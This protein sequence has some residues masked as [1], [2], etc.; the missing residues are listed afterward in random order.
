MEVPGGSFH[1]FLLNRFF[2]RPES[3]RRY[4][5]SHSRPPLLTGRHPLFICMGLVWTGLAS[6]CGEGGR[7]GS[8]PGGDAP[9]PA[10]EP[11][12]L[13][14]VR[15]AV[16][17]PEHPGPSFPEDT[18]T[19]P[20]DTIL[21]AT[22][23]VGTP[24]DTVASASL[25][26]LPVYSTRMAE[27]GIREGEGGGEGSVRFPHPEHIRGIYLNA[28]TSGS[29]AGRG[30]LLE[31]AKRTELNAFVMDIKDASGYV[32]HDSQ[33]PLAREVGATG[34]RRIRDLP[35]LLEELEEAGVYPI[36]RIVVAKDP[37]L[38]KGRP[39]LAI[40]DSAGGPWEDQ[41]GVMWLNFYHPEVWQYHLDLAREVAEA[42]FPEIQWDYVRF[43]DAPEAYLSRAR[44]PHQEGRSRTQA[45]REFL[46]RSRDMLNGMGVRLTADVF[47]VTT[48]YRRDVGIGQL[49]ESFID[50]VD[51]ALPMV[52]P[53]HYWTGSFGYQEPNAYPY[54]IVRRAL[55]DGLKRSAEV[56][57]AGSIRPWLQD[58]SLG[59]P[60][61]GAPEVRAQIQ[62]AYDVGIQEW[63]LWNPGS[64]YTEAALIPAT[65]LP[66]W[67]EPV[68]RVG[69]EVVAVSRRFEI[70]GETGAEPRTD[71]GP[72]L[73]DPELPGLRTLPGSRALPAVPLPDTGWVVHRR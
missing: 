36:A 2:M 46:G 44:F 26:G 62:A 13:E 39:D 66:S 10:P 47:G 49:W 6:G 69:G 8:G 15:A 42:G 11:G 70:L 17:P 40:Q 16:D 60:P 71:A 30:R 18:A 58:F 65:G 25:E 48:S 24:E 37:L 50:Q 68:M 1:A 34:E 53:S 33:V 73:D 57:G 29:T 23:V 19:L 52:Y 32:S 38:A 61:Y 4:P 20:D 64:R 5:R 45:V 21:T 3:L 41:N 22:V 43:P 9:I 51:V 31:L 12:A 27:P 72:V 63:I 56:E 28:W 59:D 7:G 54:E 67:L 55:R 14:D 35:A